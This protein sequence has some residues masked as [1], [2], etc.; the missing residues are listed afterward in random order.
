M[1]LRYNP[2]QI[3]TASK[4]PAGLYA[5]QKWIGQADTRQWKTDFE[6][7]VTT[8]FADQADDGSWHQSD[9][10]TIS[11]LFGLHLTVRENSSRIDSALNWLLNRL[12]RQ[13]VDGSPD[14]EI[15]IIKEKIEGLPFISS[16]KDLFFMSAT[17]FLTSIFGR[18]NDPFVLESYRWL[19]S[20]GVKNNGLLVDRACSHNILRAMV[21]HPEFSKDSATVIAVESLA[22][23]QLESGEWEE[24]LPFF[25][26]LNAL[27]HLDLPEAEKQLE[28][29]FFRLFK[30][31]QSNG[32]WSDTESEWNTFLAVH[33]MR[34]KGLL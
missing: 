14:S 4:T 18:D 11:R 1:N 22:R 12:N 25:Q 3:F 27:A 26:T 24:D 34:N 16:R 7:T 13:S 8:L 30:L 15:D 28:K 17:L 32:S 33:A 23:V 5:R 2:Y 6:E 19:S 9:V 29:A 20:A 21:V 10:E 31:Q